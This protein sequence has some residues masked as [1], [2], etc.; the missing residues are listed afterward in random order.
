MTPLDYADCYWN[1]Q[2]PITGDAGTEIRTVNVHKYLL[3]N[4]QSGDVNLPAKDN[5]LSKVRAHLNKAGTVE[6]EVVRA[7]NG[8]R[9]SFIFT[10][11]T[12]LPLILLRPFIGKGSP[13]ENQVVLQLAVR[14]G[15]ATKDTLQQYADANLGLDCN[16]FV[17]NYIRQVYDGTL[18][19][20][21]Y[22]SDPIHG[23]SRI[24][25]LIHKAGVRKKKVADLTFAGIQIMGLV[26]HSHEIV[27][28]SAPAGHVVISEP[29]TLTNSLAPAVVAA[30]AGMSLLAGAVGAA[31][32]TIPGTRP[33]LEVVESTGANHNGLVKS[34]YVIASVDGH[35]I[36]HLE[37]GLGMGT[38]A[39]QVYTMR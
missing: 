1:L 22:Q 10:D 13:E 5:L 25:D 6:V 33:S 29:F 32:K 14:H 15:L 7:I 17:G 35:G 4:M 37:R 36:F 12:D 23:S 18:K 24:R 2:V 28:T 39:V 9:Q 27:N 31:L 34:T 8:T 38:L 11:W 3:V 30:T 16:G 21:A 20:Y 26:D 19:W